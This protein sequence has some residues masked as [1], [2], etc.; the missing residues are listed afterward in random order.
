M[1]GKAQKLHGV[2]YKLN[3]LFSLQKVDQWNPLEHLPYSPDLTLCN[4]CAFPT[5]KGEL[6]GKF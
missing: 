3:S 1:V 5:M 6:Q 4:F 2:R